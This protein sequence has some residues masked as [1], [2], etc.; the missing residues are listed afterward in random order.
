MNDYNITNTT[1]GNIKRAI[2]SAE[3]SLFIAESTNTPL[4]KINN[5]ALKTLVKVARARLLAKAIAD[6]R[7]EDNTNG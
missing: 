7:S 2:A 3:T 5:V 4:A 6:S 1:I